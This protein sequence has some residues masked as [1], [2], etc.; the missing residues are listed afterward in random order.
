MLSL[1]LSDSQG[2]PPL[3]PARNLRWRVLRLAV[4][5]HL[6]RDSLRE[7]GLGRLGNIQR[8]LRRVPPARTAS[9]ADRSGESGMTEPGEYEAAM[10][11]IGELE[12]VIERLE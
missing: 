8:G 2:S 12:Q 7:L 9:S 1:R 3:S 11:R 6:L 4:P 10:D 5:F